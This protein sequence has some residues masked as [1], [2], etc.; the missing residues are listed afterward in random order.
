MTRIIAPIDSFLRTMLG[1][2]APAGRMWARVGLVV[3]FVA[4]AMSYDF[5][6]AVSWK[7]AIFLAL[8]SFVAAFGPEVAHKAW[9]EGKRGPAIAIAF[10]C[11]PLLGIEFYSHAGY[12]AG[13]RGHNITEARVAN[14][15]YDGAQEATKEDKDNL[16]TWKKQL[17]TLM[18]QNAW[19]TTVKADGLRAEL[20]TL[21][22]RIEEEKKGNRGRKAGCGKECERL[23]NEAN[24]LEQ[25]IGT[26]EQ[27]AS[28]N[29]RI[30]ATQRVLDKKRAVAN[31]TEYKSSAV[32]HQNQFL[33]DAVSLV[34]FGQLQPTATV[35]VAAQQSANIAMALVGTGL[36]AF[37][38][39]IAGL[40]RR[41]ATDQDVTEPTP[42]TSY[43]RTPNRARM[44]GTGYT[45]G[46]I[47]IPR[48]A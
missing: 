45:S 13:L 32:V 14:V 21:R 12:T 3:L 7:H 48:A 24:A 44:L 34:A 15:K 39:F 23:Q 40:Y 38:F 25:R 19:A 33:A 43:D 9:G 4:A 6:A 18:A 20:E 1:D 47:L 29:A 11:V 31:A 27:V 42:A 2:L 5:G 37:A 8:L 30:E 17:A 41:R 36:P 35:Q 28:L 16:E 46:P 10:I 22:T 26:V